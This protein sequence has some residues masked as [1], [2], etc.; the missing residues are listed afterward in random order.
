[1]KTT[2]ILLGKPL[3]AICE[4]VSE[5]MKKLEN[6]Y[7]ILRVNLLSFFSKNGQIKELGTDKG[8][9]F[10]NNFFKYLTYIPVSVFKYNPETDKIAFVDIS[11]FL[12]SALID[13]S[14]VNIDELKKTIEESPYD[15]WPPTKKE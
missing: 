15:V 13:I 2:L 7:D 5:L 6:D 4:T 10:I 1:M 3:C 9:I 12:N 14:F 8:S 11:N